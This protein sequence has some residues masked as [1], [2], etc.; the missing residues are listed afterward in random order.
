MVCPLHKHFVS[1]AASVRERLMSLGSPRVLRPPP[2]QT[3]SNMSTKCLAASDQA[4]MTS[5][6]FSEPPRVVA[7]PVALMTCL[8]PIAS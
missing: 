5:G 1:H 3:G 6:S 8:T 4:A 2:C 7:V